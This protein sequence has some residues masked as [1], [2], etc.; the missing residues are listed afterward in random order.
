M[1][2]FT[3]TYRI[4]ASDARQAFARAQG[5]AHEQTVEVPPD[6]VP[7]GYVRDEIVGR[8]EEL[9]PEGDSVF[10]AAISYSPDSAGPDIAQLLNVVFGNSSIQKGI[11]V[12]HLDPGE[13]ILRRH[14]GARFGVE[15]LQRLAGRPGSGLIAPVLKPQGIGAEE[16]ARIAYLCALGGAD[17]VK[18]DHGLSD[19]RMAPF[20]PRVEAVVA[21][22]DRAEAET[23]RRPLYFATLPGPFER[24]EEAIAFAKAAR[25]DGLLTM[26]GLFGFGLIARIARDEAL[27]MP[28]MAHPSFL[29]SFV[30]PEDAGIAHGVMFGTIQRLA[31]SDISVFPNVGGRFGFSE[32]ECRSIA[33][34]C[35]D[36]H[37][38]GRPILPSPGGGMSVDRAS[39][40]RAMYGSDVVYLLGGSLLRSG[41]AIGEEIARM[42]RALDA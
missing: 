11:R 30:L 17:I 14:P 3:V 31:G 27:A 24:I 34:A 25:V 13:E 35:L 37:G 42:R 20:R 10:R 7:Q 15:G 1:T 19:Q 23:G 41:E 12:I 32:A 29:G 16:L 36:P 4:T 21:A 39:D 40:M 38:P 33:A 2:R 8:I 18:E 6:V 5:I 22:L 28:V 9:G 26:P